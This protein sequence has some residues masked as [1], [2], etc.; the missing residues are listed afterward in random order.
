MF[1]VRGFP[2]YLFWTVCLF[3]DH[4]T[5]TIKAREGWRGVKKQEQE[6]DKNEK[7]KEVK[8]V[9]DT[10]EEEVEEEPYQEE[11]DIEQ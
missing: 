2:E 10:E 9:E 7:G 6:E 5:D 8:K 4:W 11:L 1:A 3:I